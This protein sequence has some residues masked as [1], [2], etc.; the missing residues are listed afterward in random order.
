MRPLLLLL[1][2]CSDPALLPAEALHPPGAQTL[3]LEVGPIRPGL[4]ASWT[5]RGLNPG[6]T[7]YLGRGTALSTNGPCL[8][9][10]GGTCL[11]IAGPPA[12]LGTPRADSSGVARLTLT[13]P[14]TLPPNLNLGFQAVAIR[15][16]RGAES[17]K[18]NAVARRSASFT[19]VDLD[20]LG[21]G[22][23][24]ITELLTD[25]TAVDDA[26]GEWVELYN[27][28]NDD[29]ELYG[30]ELGAARLA[31]PLVLPAG[32]LAVI[33]ASADPALNGG[34]DVDR[35]WTGALS[36]GD[37]AGSLS[38]GYAG[39]T[40]D[41]ITWAD[42]AAPGS[43]LALDPGAW[44]A[45]A[46]CASTPTPGQVNAACPV[47][48]CGDGNLDPGEACDDHN[49]TPGDGCDDACLLE[50]CQ[51]PELRVGEWRLTGGFPTRSQRMPDGGTML[52]GGTTYNGDN[53]YWWGALDA[54]YT[55]D[56]FRRA[57]NSNRDYYPEAVAVAADGSYSLVGRYYASAGAAQ[58]EYWISVARF[59]A[60]GQLLAS[61]LYD[62]YQ[63]WTM[64][65][66]DAVA[67]AD[68]GLIIVGETSYDPF[69]HV[70]QRGIT[71]RLDADGNVMWNR[72]SPPNST[73]FR[74]LRRIY[75]LRDGTYII[76]NTSNQLV[77]ITGSGGV[78]WSRTLPSLTSD[79]KD[80]VELENGDLAFAGQITGQPAAL[81][82]DISG[83]PR[84][85]R[86]VDLP[87]G[88][89]NEQRQ[90]VAVPASCPDAP[91]DG[92]ACADPGAWCA[93]ATNLC[94][95]EPNG[96]WSCA[97]GEQQVAL[98]WTSANVTA[99]GAQSFISM[100]NADGSVDEHVQVTGLG[101]VTDFN[102]RPNGALQL[103][104]LGT[105][106]FNFYET[107]DALSGCGMTNA[108]LEAYEQTLPNTDMRLTSLG[109][110]DRLDLTP[111]FL[112]PFAF[113]TPTVTEHCLG[114]ICPE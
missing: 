7:V 41:T 110:S 81:V 36:L 101:Y 6:E 85:Q 91:T 49:L 93:E 68:G 108:E 1:A 107:D 73:S 21:A 86:Y 5:V 10:A 83:Y 90:I 57:A 59:D 17:V 62:H 30:L 99:P 26:L 60:A 29:V 18:S 102:V 55:P 19:G 42:L 39:L 103:T 25:P 9:A 35:A 98:A 114:S 31:E 32:G 105:G 53:Q 112:A 33:G 47:P 95:C 71:I 45:E 109:T 79:L 37:A 16:L 64:L 15:G 96:T 22:D 63:Y 8:A 43:A 3:T 50:G 46:W 69:Y 27:P 88:S 111:D 82:Y 97:P 48:A 100:F 65:P 84:W 54:D 74:F 38:V 44:D 72:F 23:L 40:L 75:P 61:H 34:A 89:T 76:S 66:Y 77:H 12:L 92:A 106:G 11:D 4:P 67:T 20:A 24:V 87:Q 80:M 104:G 13:L 28:G 14:A 2:A 78:L 70:E 94:S 113:T 56:A 51:L 52:F 58:R